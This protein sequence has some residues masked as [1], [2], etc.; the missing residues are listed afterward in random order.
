[1]TE[2]IEDKLNREEQNNE[3]KD[4]IRKKK[5]IIFLNNCLLGES[6]DWET[7][8]AY[9]KQKSWKSFFFANK[10]CV[11]LEKNHKEC[12][13][14]LLKYYDKYYEKG[15]HNRE[16]LADLLTTVSFDDLAIENIA[17]SVM[18]MKQSPDNKSED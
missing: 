14:I 11:L 9:L 6:M 12:F 15:L 13:R 4:T 18:D 7:F 5:I 1:M 8:F 16:S 10:K 3:K 17:K 2:I